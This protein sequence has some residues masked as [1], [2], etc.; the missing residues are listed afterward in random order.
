MSAVC[1]SSDRAFGLSILQTQTRQPVY[2][3]PLQLLYDDCFFLS[4]TVREQGS[5]HASGCCRR[6]FMALICWK[7]QDMSVASTISTTR[8]RSSLKERGETLLA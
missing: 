8:V 6:L 2:T 5:T 3:T 7:W 1:S 4:L